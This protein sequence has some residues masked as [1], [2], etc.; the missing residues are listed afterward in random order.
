VRVANIFDSMATCLQCI[1]YAKSISVGRTISSMFGVLRIISGAHGAFRKD[2]LQRIHGWDVG[3]GLDGDITLKI[4][5]LGFK[6]V[7]EP[8][9]I[10]YTNTPVKFSKLAKQRFR[11]DRSMVRF[12]MRKHLDILLPSKGF[13]P[14]NFISSLDN[15][16]FNFILNI[17]WWVYIT[18]LILMSTDSETVMFIFVINYLLYFLANLFEYATAC[19]LYAKTLRLKHL[20]LFIYIPLAPLYTGFFLRA[21]RSYAYMMELFFKV[22]YNDAWNPWKVS[23]VAKKEGL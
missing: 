14:L 10:C 22:S 6:I 5:K 3:P 20:F 9:A 13:K 16:F 1:E 21:V 11:W 17:K 15:I 8:Q 19:L 2:I 7:H 12:R 23:K 4:R 18:Q